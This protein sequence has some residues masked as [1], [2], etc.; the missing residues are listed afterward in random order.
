[1]PVIWQ[2]VL[3]HVLLALALWIDLGVVHKRPET[4]TTK[5]APPCVPFSHDAV[6]PIVL[7][8]SRTIARPMPVPTDR[9]ADS[10]AV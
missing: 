10:R 4:V 7:A 8:S 5:R 9:P 6:P 2:W 3:F 1:M